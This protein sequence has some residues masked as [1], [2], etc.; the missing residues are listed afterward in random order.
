MITRSI[1]LKTATIVLWM[2]VW[3]THAQHNYDNQ[4]TL[5][6]LNGHVGIGT[7]SPSSLLEINSNNDASEIT[8][9]G[10]G[11]GAINAGVVLK[12]THSDANYRGLGVFMHDQE[13]QNEWFVGRPYA[14]SDQFVIY[15]RSNT[16][17]HKTV[18]ASLGHNSGSEITESLLNIK[19]N[20]NVGIGTMSPSAALHINSSAD[21]GRG[22]DPALLIGDRTGYHIA[23]D[24]NEMGAFYNNSNAVLYING[25]E[26]TSHTIINGGGTGNVG[27]GTT[28]PGNY[29]LAVDGNIRAKEVV[30]ETGWSDFVF[31]PSYDLP[32]LEEV[33][34][35]ILEKGHLQ[36][37]PSAAEVAEHGV[38][39][40]EMDAKLLQKIEELML[41]TIAQQ[42]QIEA[43][44]ARLEKHDRMNDQE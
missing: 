21:V 3:E 33:E 25:S 44:K 30:V 41:Y 43:L 18:T 10:T 14:S 27:I 36:D 38:S 8:L 12:A 26:S 29:R 24:D 39:L 32:T 19:S 13:G 1:L 17:D 6:S 28:D 20:G 9:K 7:N 42:K 15:R 37:I 11:S 40:G 35:H 4:N 2:V 23:I 5:Y 22:Q 31:E 34:A 16:P